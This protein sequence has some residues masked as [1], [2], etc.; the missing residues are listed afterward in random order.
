MQPYLVVFA[1]SA[2]VTFVVTPLV[3]RLSLRLGWVDQPSDRK[4][5]PRPTPTV[6]GLA[7]FAGVAA[8]LGVTHV[9]PSLTS[10]HETTSELD[11]A[12]V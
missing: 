8:A 3:R 2:G 1:V 7:I 4:V 12:L 5:H 10:L 6:G 11:A 9:L